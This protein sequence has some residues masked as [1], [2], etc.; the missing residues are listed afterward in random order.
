MDSLYLFNGT[1]TTIEIP[2]KYFCTRED[3][4]FLWLLLPIA[5]HSLS[6][7]LA[8][9]TVLEF[10]CAQA[11][12]KMKGLLIGLWYATTSLQI[13]NN[14]RFV[15]EDIQ[16]FISHGIKCAWSHVIQVVSLQSTSTSVQN[17]YEKE[18]EQREE[19][20]RELREERRALLCS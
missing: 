17:R 10:I 11:P 9:M 20:K 3:T 18:I 14:D 12:L 1:C 2:F 16:W 7:Q 5:L 6:Y 19:Y 4:L 8:F 13:H 15:T